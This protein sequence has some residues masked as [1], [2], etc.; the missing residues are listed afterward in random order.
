MGGGHT[1]LQIWPI[2]CVVDQNMAKAQSSV[3]LS[4]NK[5][6]IWTRHPRKPL[7]GL[8]FWYPLQKLSFFGVVHFRTGRQ[9]NLFWT[10]ETIKPVL[11]IYPWRQIHNFGQSWNPDLLS[12]IVRYLC[13]YVPV[14]ASSLNYS[15][16]AMRLKH[17]YNNKI[18]GCGLL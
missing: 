8:F 2:W 11:N 5:G 6:Q 9:S 4:W 15:F 14:F 12:L 10:L 13:F 17:S 18:H 3:C 1:L 16:F 7:H